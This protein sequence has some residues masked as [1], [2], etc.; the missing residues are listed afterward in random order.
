MTEDGLKDS[1][2]HFTENTMHSYTDCDCT[3]GRT[4]HI[5]KGLMNGMTSLDLFVKDVNSRG[6]S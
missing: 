1:A 3:K 6:L 5:H 2:E 4:E